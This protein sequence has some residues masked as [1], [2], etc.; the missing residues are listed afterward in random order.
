MKNILSIRNLLIILILIILPIA[1]FYSIAKINEFRNENSIKEIDLKLTVANTFDT[2]NISQ[3][4]LKNGVLKTK[5]LDSALSFIFSFDFDSTSTDY[6]TYESILSSPNNDKH[7][8]LILRDIDKFH[9]LER[10]IPLNSFTSLVN[11][12]GQTTGF[13][14]SQSA[15]M[16]KEDYLRIHS[17]EI[18]WRF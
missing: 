15:E 16:K 14:V 18:S 8:I 6:R 12:N 7:I 13:S 17:W 5:Y 11:E 9:V 10:E 1:I 3:I 4:G 2:L